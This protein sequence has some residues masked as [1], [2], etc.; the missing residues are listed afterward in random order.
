MDPISRYIYWADQGQKPS[1]QRAY[2]DG[3]NKEVIVNENLKEPTD[4][5]VDSNNHM[6]YWTDAGMD[7]IYRVKS[8]GGIPELVRSDIAEA[9]GITLIRQNMFWTDRRLEKVFS[10]SR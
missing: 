6:L 10:A 9:T 2:L 3:S 4:L 5:S 7:G 8:E 1:I